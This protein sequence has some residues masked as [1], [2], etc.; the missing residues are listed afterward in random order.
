[1]QKNIPCLVP[2]LL[3]GINVIILN[4]ILGVSCVWAEIPD[5]NNQELQ[6]VEAEDE[7][8]L[9]IYDP[10]EGMNRKFFW[11]NERLDL[12][13][14]GPVSKGYDYIT[15]EEVQ[16]GF[17][18]FFRNLEFPT[19]F[20]AD[21]FQAEFSDAAGQLGR[22][23][24]NTT[25]G[26][27]GFIDVASD[28]GL[29]DSREDFGKVFATWGIPEG[30]YIVLPLLGPSNLRNTVG[31]VFDV[32]TSP[33][34]LIQR[35]NASDDFKFW[36]PL[37]T[38]ALDIINFRNNMDDA[39]TTGRT[40]ALDFYLFQQNSYYQMRRGLESNS[41]NSNNGHKD[42]AAQE[43]IEDDLDAILAGEK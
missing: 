42:S 41:K 23:L 32:I 22:F 9:N 5:A 38:N 12:N 17:T 30:P 37:T 40:G 20:A 27:L 25:V 28:I 35:S 1:M 43:S 2:A 18:N 19:R 11:L 7:S 4:I 13:I 39:I 3:N 24:I 21:I 14:L 33:S 10:L 15:P 26:L 29:E 31:R 6:T 34:L 8:D 16:I 36:W